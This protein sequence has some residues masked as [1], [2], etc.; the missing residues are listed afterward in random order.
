MSPTTRKGTSFSAS[1]ANQVVVLSSIDDLAMRT[2]SP[3][4]ISLTDHLH[5]PP[6][7]ISNL[8]IDKNFT[9]YAVD[10]AV[11]LVSIVSHVHVQNMSYSPRE[12]RPFGAFDQLPHFRVRA[13]E[14]VI[15]GFHLPS[16]IT[17]YYK[18]KDESYTNTILRFD[19]GI[20]HQCRVRQVLLLGRLT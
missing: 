4:L 3:T 10:V 19:I 15:M 8:S 2:R 17:L 12:L 20:E 1:R 14:L 18:R 16:E 11:L 9:E 7:K 6:E 13:P 5:I